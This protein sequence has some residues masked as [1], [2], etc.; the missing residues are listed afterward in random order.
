MDRDET[1]EK[2]VEKLAQRL[3]EHLPEVSIYKITL[4][5]EEESHSDL[6]DYFTQRRGTADELFSK[7]SKYICGAKPIDVSAFKEIG[8]DDIARILDLTIKEDFVCKVVVFLVMLSTYTEDSQINAMLNGS[9]GAGKSFIVNEVSKLFPLPDIKKYDRMSPTAPFY[10][11]DLMK[12]DEQGRKYVDLERRILVLTENPNTALLEVLR[13]FLSHDADDKMISHAL[14]NKE[15]NGKNTAKEQY[16]RGY[17]SII[18]CT[19]SMRVDDQEQTRCIMLSPENTQ[20][21]IMKAVDATIAKN[22]SR[23]VYDAK[24]ENNEERRLLKE[25]ILYI[26]GLKVDY[27]DIADGEYL[28]RRFLEGREVLKSEDPRKTNQFASLVK[29]I[30]LLNAPFRM[31]NGRVTATRKDIDEAMKL[32]AS[33]S[34]SSKR[35][36]SPQALWYYRQI[37]QAYKAVNEASGRPRERWRGIT[38]EEFRK[39]FRRMNGVNLSGDYFRKNVIEALVDASLINYEMRHSVDSRQKLI[40]P[41]VF[42]DDDLE[43][44]EQK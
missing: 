13:P 9:S 20:E 40:T 2:G 16:I 33:L 31:V 30:A 17:S 37:L 24:V 3:A 10:L 44:T 42:L 5:F 36:V 23:T 11:E 41:L 14:T 25:R 18:F 39:E 15:K 38:N 7:Y 12:V 28:K 34:E 27:I 4:P 43:K 6:T 26:K 21:K 19:A 22:S 8:V 35:G 1:G 29:A 32:W